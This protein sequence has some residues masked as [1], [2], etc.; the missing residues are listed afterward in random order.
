MPDLAT[1]LAAGYLV[2]ETKRDTSWEAK[3]L[4]LVGNMLPD[5]LTRPFFALF[6]R[7]HWFFAPL[8]TPVGLILACGVA[9]CAFEKRLRGV[10][11][12]ALA[13]GAGLHLLLDALQKRVVD[14]YGILFP[15]TWKDVYVGWFWPDESLYGL[16]VLLTV[17]LAGIVIRYRSQVHLEQTSSQ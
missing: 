12:R 6:P 8:H 17:I 11:F 1:H 10:A 2:A 5:L 16:P 13:L 4:F 3:A 7:L 15:L 9:S 14:A